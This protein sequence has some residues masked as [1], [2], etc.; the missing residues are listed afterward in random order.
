MKSR[1]KI[2]TSSS[3]YGAGQTRNRRSRLPV[4]LADRHIN[5]TDVQTKSTSSSAKLFVMI[6]EVIAPPGMTLADLDRSMQSIREEIAVD[7]TVQSLE[8]IELRYDGHTGDPGPIPIPLLKQVS[9]P[10]DL[11]DLNVQALID[12]LVEPCSPSSSVSASPHH[13]GRA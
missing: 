9:A 5:I 8:I 4:A 13:K 11:C 12:D 7:I 6:L 10:A 1:A 3:V 2:N